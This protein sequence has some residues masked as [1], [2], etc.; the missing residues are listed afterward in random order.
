[1]RHLTIRR[2]VIKE[3]FKHI[4]HVGY[5]NKEGFATNLTRRENSFQVLGTNLRNQHVTGDQR[6]IV[7]VRVRKIITWAV[8][9]NRAQ[10]K[11]E[12][13]LP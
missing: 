6:I 5:R 8:E 2:P 10:E 12:G 7:P 11:Q 13:S 1:M 4:A 3:L 9:N